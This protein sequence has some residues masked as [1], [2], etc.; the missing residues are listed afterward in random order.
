MDNTN[1][2]TKRNPRRAAKDRYEEEKLMTSDKSQLID[3]DLV[4]LLSL[5]EA[6]NCLEEAE[7][8]EILDLLPSDTHPNPNP[9]PD[10]PE[11]KIP[12]LPEAFLRYSNNWRDGIRHFQL[13]L[14]N[15]RFDPVWI[16]E[17]EEAMQQRAAG[18]FD[19]F[20]EQEF[21]EFWGQKQKMDRGLTAGESSRVKLSTLTEHDVV[22]K[23]DIWKWSRAFGRKNNL[24]IE[25]EARIIE[26]NG[27]HLTFIVPAGQRIFLKP[28]ADP[29]TKA[30][31][32]EE[33][34][35]PSSETT[36]ISQTN[37]GA[38]SDAKVDLDTYDAEAGLSRKRT[39]E[40]E[41]QITPTKRRRGRPR[42]QQSAPTDEKASNLVV[43]IVNSSQPE[44]G[45][46]PAPSNNHV[47]L[48]SPTEIHNDASQ[49]VEEGQQDE[50]LE[51]MPF[52]QPMDEEC[53]HLV[54]EANG[55]PDEIV[56]PNIQG[57]TALTMK[58]LEID[59]R[60]DNP[61]NGN[62]WKEIRCFRDNQDMGT[63]WEVRQAWFVKSR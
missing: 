30:P 14:Q 7:K 25:K 33:H 35:E 40:P 62:A 37:G 2:K 48:D 41:I 18:K 59:G 5:P 54:P 49:T 38:T 10:D 28:A 23:G 8:K 13:D 31:V 19:K 46:S 56:I 47:D 50:K 26:I 9:P 17:A 20:K 16:R 43:E 3:L 22:R 36:L 63:L 4:K 55:D 1:T 52:S 60:V 34:A 51:T 24:L 42:K 44:N 21:E 57:P 12:P 6:W 15:G 45:T 11:A 61:P 58:M 39:A 27:A 53:S 29:D 32:T